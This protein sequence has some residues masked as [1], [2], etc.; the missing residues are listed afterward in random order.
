M[1]AATRYQDHKARCIAEANKHG[2]TQGDTHPETGRVFFNSQF[3]SASAYQRSRIRGALVSARK[4]AA[5]QNL[6]FDLTEA[7]YQA[8]WPPNGRCE[9]IPYIHLEW[10]GS[11]MGTSPSIDRVVPALGYMQTN[12]RIISHRANMLKS[13]A[14]LQEMELVL[15]YLR[16]HDSAH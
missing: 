5:E 4:R 2:L 16:K 14:T 3:Y 1:T 11:D 10:G 15:A 8:M 9:V 7:W 12:C 13:N 6:P